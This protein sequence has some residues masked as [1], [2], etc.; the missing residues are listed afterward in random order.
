MKIEH[1]AAIDSK[2]LKEIDFLE[3]EEFEGGEAM[4]IVIKE[5]LSDGQD[6]ESISRNQTLKFDK[7]PCPKEFELLRRFSKS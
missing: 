7:I 1:T 4:S 2:L 3:M 6:D 5:C